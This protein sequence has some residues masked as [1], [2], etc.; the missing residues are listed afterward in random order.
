MKYYHVNIFNIFTNKQTNKKEVAFNLLYTHIYIFIS[1]SIH[2]YQMSLNIRAQLY[3]KTDTDP[4]S[5][6]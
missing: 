4:P 1:F 3:N 2:N 5:E 6:P